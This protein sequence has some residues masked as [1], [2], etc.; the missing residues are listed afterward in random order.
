MQLPHAPAPPPP[1][2]PKKKVKK[3]LNSTWKMQDCTSILNPK[4]PQIVGFP[5]NQDPNKV[6]PI[7]NPP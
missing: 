2:P 1:P 3:V 4:R 6:P 7:G 5:D